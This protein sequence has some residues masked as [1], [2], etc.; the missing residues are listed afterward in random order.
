[1][2]ADAMTLSSTVKL[3]NNRM[4]WNGKTQRFNACIDADGNPHEYGYTFL[5]LEAVYYDFATP[6][7]AKGILSWVNGDRLVEGDTAQGADIYHWRDAQVAFG[8]VDLIPNRRR[9]ASL[10]SGGGMLLFYFQYYLDANSMTSFM[11]NLNDSMGG[12][13]KVIGLAG[14]NAVASD[15][16]FGITNILGQLGAILGIVVSNIMVKRM[17]KRKRIYLGTP[18]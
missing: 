14:Q 15:S 3:G 1:M 9:N 4:F 5:N 8:I 12:F 10:L 18:A 6:E 7:H 13:L 16:I 11:N 2:K 17:G